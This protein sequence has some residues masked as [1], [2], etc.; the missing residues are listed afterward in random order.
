MKKNINWESIDDKIKELKYPLSFIY[1]TIKTQDKIDDY[2]LSLIIRFFFK[3]QIELVMKYPIFVMTNLL[4][5]KFTM[6]KR[7][8]DDFYSSICKKF[9]FTQTI[10]KFKNCFNNQIFWSKNFEYQITKLENLEAIFRS[11]FDSSFTGLAGVTK[12]VSQIRLRNNSTV[13][14]EIK[15]RFYKTIDIFGIEFFKANDIKIIMEDDFDNITTENQ[16]K[17]LI[18]Y[19]VKV[20]KCLKTIINI[21]ELLVIYDNKIKQ[22]VSPRPIDINIDITCSDNDSEDFNLFF[23]H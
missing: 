8:V 14:N 13:Y 21:Y 9:L 2:D 1:S 15:S 10:L 11:Y 3:N 17:Y 16:I 12:F 18:Y 5:H 4:D 19:F 22:I 6:T 23:D 7:V 20:Q